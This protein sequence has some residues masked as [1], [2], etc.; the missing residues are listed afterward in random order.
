MS[1]ESLPPV[2]ELEPM[3]DL[4]KALAAAQNGETTTAEFLRRL[5]A[6]EVFILLNQTQTREQDEDTAEVQPLILEGPDKTPMLAMF[7]DPERVSPL[8]KEFPDFTYPLE[9]EFS[10]IVANATEGMGLVINPGWSYAASLPPEA[11][12]Q[13]RNKNNKN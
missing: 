4:E 12:D 6:A 11:L 1:D 2:A 3:N 9:V 7:T 13:L 10:W 5:V 8:T